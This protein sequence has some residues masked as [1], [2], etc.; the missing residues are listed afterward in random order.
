MHFFRSASLGKPQ[1]AGRLISCT[2]TV[3]TL[4]WKKLRI[5]QKSNNNKPDFFTSSLQIEAHIQEKPRS[6]RTMNMEASWTPELFNSLSQAAPARVSI[7]EIHIFQFGKAPNINAIQ[8][9]QNS[10]QSGYL[11]AL[12]WFRLCQQQAAPDVAI[13]ELHSSTFPKKS[14]LYFSFVSHCVLY[15]IKNR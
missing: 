3:N 7:V 10:D 14:S 2:G 13:K 9:L 8:N 12:I 11:L 4:N 15:I 1:T 6:L 5:K